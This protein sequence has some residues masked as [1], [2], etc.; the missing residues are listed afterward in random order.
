[1]SDVRASKFL[2]LVLRHS[3]EAAG[4]SLDAE[5]WAD[6]DAIL[7]AT[8]KIRDYAHLLHVVETNDKK[9]FVLSEDGRSIRAAQG[10]SVR[11]DLGL[12]PIEPPQ[13][14]FHGTAKKNLDAIR[15]EG[16]KPRNRQYVHLSP[17]EDVATKVG[18]RH[19]TPVVLLV[20]SKRAYSEGQPF[21]QA[22]NGVWLTSPLAPDYLTFPGES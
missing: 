10:H 4:L 9:R 5:G 22:E 16:L 19:G 18:R 1:M 21:F 17:N 11:V 2:S 13:I 20:A 14:L 15:L 8:D 6:V 7:S 3:P 12:Q